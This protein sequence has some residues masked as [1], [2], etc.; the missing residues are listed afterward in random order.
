MKIAR[1]IL[2]GVGA[3]AL[4]ATPALADPPNN[5]NNHDDEGISLEIKD[6][7][8]ANNG[9]IA[10]AKGGEVDANSAT[11]GS[12]AAAQGGRISWDSSTNVVANQKLVA[13]NINHDLDEVVDLDGTDESQSNVGYNSGNNSIR[14]NAFAAYAGILNQAWNTGIN[15]NTQ[16]ATNIAAQGTVNFGGDAPAGGGGGGNED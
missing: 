5:N 2:T 13:M 10:A 1:L 7:N 3:A 14:G 15:A 9:S 11:N 4:F 16:A 6:I 12:N 8:A